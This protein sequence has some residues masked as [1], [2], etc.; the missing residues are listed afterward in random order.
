[1]EA[2]E[3]IVYEALAA[4]GIPYAR[5]EH[6]PVFTVEEARVHWK[7]IPGAHCK[8][9][10]LR[11]KKG[12]R[13]YLVVA[14]FLKTVDLRAAAKALGDDRLSFASD[15]RLARSLGLHPGEV[16]PFGLLQDADRR[17]IVVLDAGLARWDKVNFHP[18][19]NTATL[20][21]SYAD[22]RRFLSSRGNR[23]VELTLGGP[24]ADDDAS[25]SG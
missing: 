10:F 8:N 14:E 19:V 23:V 5:H 17:V 12:N 15:E 22:L 16:S 25:S 3:A 7:D 4:L 24:G 20:T 11:N 21:I 9:L 1:M 6:P 13:H 2:R 18:N